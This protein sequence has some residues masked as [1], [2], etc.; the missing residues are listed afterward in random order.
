MHLNRANLIAQWFLVRRGLFFIET[1][2]ARIPSSKFFLSFVANTDWRSP[3]NAENG[4]SWIGLFL[5]YF[6]GV[7]IFYVDTYPK[8]KDKE[9]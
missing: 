8:D 3:R 5:F 4:I 6:K 2:T 9:F 7:F 1:Q